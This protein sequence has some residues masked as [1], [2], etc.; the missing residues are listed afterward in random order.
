MPNT[1]YNTISNWKVTP[2][3]MINLMV[4]DLGYVRFYNLKQ[5][6]QWSLKPVL[7]K[8]DEGGNTIVAIKFEGKFVITQ[9]DFPNML[10]DL[11]NMSNYA[12]TDFDMELQAASGQ[13]NGGHVWFSVDGTIDSVNPVLKKWFVTWEINQTDLWGDAT[14]IVSGIFSKDILKINSISDA[15]FK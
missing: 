11:N 10:A 7:R 8:N 9:N 6:S 2:I 3:H 15:I 1:T 5:G 12:I 14:I 13:P 4:K